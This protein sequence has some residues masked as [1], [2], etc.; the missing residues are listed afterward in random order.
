MVISR[1]PQKRFNLREILEPCKPQLPESIG[2][3][4]RWIKGMQ[5]KAKI[6][7]L[8]HKKNTP[9][10]M[11]D[12]PH[13]IPEQQDTFKLPTLST[14]RNQVSVYP[15]RSQEQDLLPGSFC[16]SL[17]PRAR[18]PAVQHPGAAWAHHSSCTW[19]QAAVSAVKSIGQVLYLEMNPFF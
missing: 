19:S 6:L 11:L 2:Y 14:F 16:R 12:I 1:H 10:I 9:S 5:C 15:D 3:A 17:V 13:T 7:L 8:S 4:D 18:V